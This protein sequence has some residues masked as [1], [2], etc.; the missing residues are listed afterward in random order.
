ME[1][2]VRAAGIHALPLLLPP[3]ADVKRLHLLL[4]HASVC[5]RLSIG[6]RHDLLHHQMGAVPPGRG[7]GESFVKAAPPCM[8]PPALF[9][10]DRSKH[11]TA[12]RRSW[13][14]RRNRIISRPWVFSCTKLAIGCVLKY[15]IITIGCKSS[16]HL[17][18]SFFFWLRAS[19]PNAAVPAGRWRFLVGHNLSTL[20]RG[21]S[22]KLKSVGQMNG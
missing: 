12:L 2:A 16:I 17:S 5:G 9:S 10:I 7:G 8:M 14:L 21:C 13:K 22:S 6:R 3:Q 4:E 18:V 20:L 11:S 15:P 19:G 1:R